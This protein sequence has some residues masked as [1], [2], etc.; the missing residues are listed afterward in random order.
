MSLVSTIEWIPVAERMPPCERRV[1]LA[2]KNWIHIGMWV[3]YKHDPDRVYWYK[4]EAGEGDA[5]IYEPVLYWAHIP[6]AESIG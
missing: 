2:E 1:F 4:W 5:Q 6:E 3:T